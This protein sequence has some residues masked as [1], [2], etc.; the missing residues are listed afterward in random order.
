LAAKCK[1]GRNDDD[2]DDDDDDDCDDDD[3]DDADD[4]DDDATTAPYIT[5]VQMT[6]HLTVSILMLPT[7]LMFS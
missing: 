2:D 7:S 5:Y 3:D 1:E 4:D 6:L